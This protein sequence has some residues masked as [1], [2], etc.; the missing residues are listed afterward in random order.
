MYV[1]IM[2]KCAKIA[3]I[4]ILVIM[5]PAVGIFG[6][7][8]FTK[9]AWYGTGGRYD[10]SILNDMG[11]I[12]ETQAD[13]YAWNEGYSTSDDCPWGFKHE[14]LDYFF[15]NNSAV[16]S[17]SPGKISS[18]QYRD[19]DEGVENRFWVT[20]EIRFNRTVILTYNFESWTN[21]SSDWENQQSMLAVEE[22]DWIEKGQEIGR[23]LHVGDGAHI[24][25]D[26]REGRIK[27]CPRKYLSQDA[28]I[29][30]LSLVQSYN[31]TWELCYYS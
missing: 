26:V 29:E 16:I 20:V 7:L 6:Y 30:L 22:G 4:I 23:F 31:P 27:P 15:N 18:I 25:F 28:Y 9:I 8:F 19:N 11:V 17:A 5:I 21:Q 12:Y 14:G 24:H 2:K 13:I 1:V 3:L 10:D